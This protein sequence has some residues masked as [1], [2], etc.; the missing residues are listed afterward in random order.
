[1]HLDV[2]MV[3]LIIL[4]LTQV[5]SNCIADKAL[6]GKGIWPLPMVIWCRHAMLPPSKQE[7]QTDRQTERQMH[8]WI[9]AL[10]YA[11]YCR[12]KH[13]NHSQNM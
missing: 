13:K 1:M 2:L 3:P 5:L 9:T 6:R 10:L 11:S 4:Y 12:V 8:G 7:R